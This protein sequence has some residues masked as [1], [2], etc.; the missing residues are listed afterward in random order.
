MYLY[1]TE[2]QPCFYRI[3][4]PS[5]TGPLLRP[6]HGISGLSPSKFMTERRAYTD[7]QGQAEN[8]SVIHLPFLSFLKFLSPRKAGLQFFS[9]QIELI[10]YILGYQNTHSFGT[11]KW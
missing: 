9:F 3:S 10:Q 5:P 1:G 2:R 6:L 11:L 8:T 4:P 7:L